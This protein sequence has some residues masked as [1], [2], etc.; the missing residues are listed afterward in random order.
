MPQWKQSQDQQ[1]L[2]SVRVRLG[3]SQVFVGL[4]QVRVR[5]GLGWGQVWCQVGVRL[6]LSQVIASSRMSMSVH[7]KCSRELPYFV[8]EKSATHGNHSVTLAPK[9]RPQEFFLGLF[10]RIINVL[11]L[12]TFPIRCFHF[13]PYVKVATTTSIQVPGAQYGRAQSLCYAI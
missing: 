5:L 9:L 11:Q 1:T 4:G 12:R 13:F 2:F 8:H 7:Q 3:L 6:G 10:L